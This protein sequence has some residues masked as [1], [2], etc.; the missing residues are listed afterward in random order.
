MVQYPRQSAMEYS[1]V[2]MLQD[3]R[4]DSE[5]LNSIL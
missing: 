5:A 3:R 1:P 2:L 4:Q